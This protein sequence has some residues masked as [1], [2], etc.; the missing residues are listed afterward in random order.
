MDSDS[1][2]MLRLNAMRLADMALEQLAAEMESVEAP[3]SPVLSEAEREAKALELMGQL[4]PA[5]F[6]D[7]WKGGPEYE[8]QMRQGLA[9]LERG[10]T[11]EPPQLPTPDMASLDRMVKALP[12]DLP[13]LTRALDEHELAQWL[14]TYNAFDSPLH[15][16]IGTILGLREL[17]SNP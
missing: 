8:A 15:E 17:E 9:E 11:F 10:D 6:M 1:F 7:G 12:P 16:L 2:E 14:P 4:D 5:E 3:A 13:P